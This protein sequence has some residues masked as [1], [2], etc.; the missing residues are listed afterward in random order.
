MISVRVELLPGKAGSPIIIEQARSL[1]IA[2]WFNTGDCISAGA[3]VTGSFSGGD[4]PLC[5]RA[6]RRRVCHYYQHAMKT[7]FHIRMIEPTTVP[8]SIERCET[9][10]AIWGP[11]RMPPDPFSYFKV[12]LQ[13]D[14]PSPIV[15]RFIT[16]FLTQHGFARIEIFS[17]TVEVNEAT[18]ASVLARQS[19]ASEKMGALPAAAAIS[20]KVTDTSE[21]PGSGSPGPAGHGK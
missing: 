10:L 12:E 6:Q 11:T 8:T 17:R 4:F 5:N 20:R 14:V 13:Y 3:A 16:R 15:S 1:A 21:I 19:K 7:S 2:L 9:G 18:I